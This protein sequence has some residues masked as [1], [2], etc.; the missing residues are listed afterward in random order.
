MLRY[1]TLVQ[2]QKAVFDFTI[3]RGTDGRN[4]AEISLYQRTNTAPSAPA[5]STYTVATDTFTIP[6]GW[7]RT[8]GSGDS[9][10]YV[11]TANFS[12]AAAT[13]TLDWNTPVRI[14]HL[15]NDGINGTNG[16]SNG[17]VRIYQRAATAPSAPAD[18]TY[19]ITNNTFTAPT[20][21]STSPPAPVGDSEVYV[22]QASY[23]TNTQATATL[24][25]GTP[26]ATTVRG[27]TG[28]VSASNIK[29]EAATEGTPTSSDFTTGV[30][31]IV[32]Y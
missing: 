3:P 22:S 29:I 4:A 31:F 7:S 32:Q 12:T 27:A 23:N 5:D 10:V 13:A 20:G 26:V 25:W 28:Q 8:I 21:W 16:Y 15:P 9:D 1:P 11:T 30:L 14:A 6:T 24:D 2:T 19:T 17:V 18:S